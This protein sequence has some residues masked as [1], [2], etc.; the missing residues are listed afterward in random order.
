MPRV[1]RSILAFT[2]GI[3]TAFALVVAVEELGARIYPPPPGL[4]LST[5]EQ[6]RNHVLELPTGALLFVLAAWVLATFAGALVAARIGRARSWVFAT[7]IGAA[8]LGAAIA[9]LLAIPHPLWFWVAALILVPLAAA[10]AAWL[11]SAKRAR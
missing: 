9:N 1:V 2:G 3:V 10:A 5:P 8:V 4:A 7:L 11:T 6:V